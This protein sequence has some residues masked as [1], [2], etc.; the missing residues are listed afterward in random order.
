MNRHPVHRNHG[1]GMMGVYGMLAIGFFMFVARYFIPPDRNSERAMK[2]SFWSLN[3][4][5][6]L[7]LFVNLAP[8]GA[9]QL[10]EAFQNGYWQAREPEFFQRPIVRLF[11]W[12]RLP[13]DLL[14]IF[15]GIVPVVYL[16]A[17]VHQSALWRSARRRD[18]AVHQVYESAEDAAVP[19]RRCHDRSCESPS[20]RSTFWL[21]ADRNN[22]Q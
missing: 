19:L 5:L 7:M 15:G 6:A 17:R 1:H 9:I 2:I 12:L 13:G 18:R 4:G 11:E 21:L 22:L 16:A 3:I 10:F 20:I 14:F 8:V